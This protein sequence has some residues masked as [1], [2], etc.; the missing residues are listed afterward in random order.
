MHR[1]RFRSLAWPRVPA[2]VLASLLGA[3]GAPTGQR[4]HDDAEREPADAGAQRDAGPTPLDGGD[5]VRDAGASAPDA[6]VPEPDAGGAIDDAGSTNAACPWGDAVPADPAV[7]LAL[8]THADAPSELERVVLLR[9][10]QQRSDAPLTWDSCLADLA[11]SHSTDMIARGY[12]GHG[13]A[14]AP[15]QFLVVQR[16]ASAGLQAAGTLDEDVLQ[17]DFHYWLHDDIAT[18]VD[19]WMSDG[20]RIPILGCDRVG[21][22]I[23]STPFLDTTIVYVTADF[24]CP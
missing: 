9:M 22:G 13:T 4:A 17:G 10:N 1:T 2:S 6:G 7:G 11:R 24:V 20:H 16:A 23:T 19:L 12:Y 14:G 5:Q 18:V 21:V 3:C 8:V 15:S